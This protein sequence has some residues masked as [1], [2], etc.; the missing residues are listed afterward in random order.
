MSELIYATRFKGTV[1]KDWTTVEFILKTNGAAY[2]QR[3]RLLAQLA[4]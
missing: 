1:R 3:N 2:H 4:M